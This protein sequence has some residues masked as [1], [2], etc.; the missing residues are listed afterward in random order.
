MRED[1]VGTEAEYYEKVQIFFY[2]NLA[3]ST[4]F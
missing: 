4:G 1:V 3:F 2:S